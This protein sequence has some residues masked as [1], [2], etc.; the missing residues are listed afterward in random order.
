MRRLV[1][2]AVLVLVGLV[3][4][5]CGDGMASTHAE[6][7]ERHRRIADIDQRQFIDDWDFF[8]HNDR[9]SRLTKW[10]TE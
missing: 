9:P 8:W 1:I 10:T 7:M 5:G 2:F 6:R 3:P 4:L